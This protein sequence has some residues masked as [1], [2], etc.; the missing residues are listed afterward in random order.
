MANYDKF[1]KQ[2][3]SKML[4]HYDR[5]DE[6][7][8]E[9]I[10]RSRSHLN[11]NLAPRAD[12]AQMDI[13][14]KRISKVKVMNRADVNVLCCWVVTMPKTLPV[15]KEPEFFRN[16]Y[17]FLENR[18]G[19]DN[20]V[21]AYVHKD[22]VTPHMHFAFIPVVQDKKRDRLKVNANECVTRL[23]L[24]K[25]HG[26]LQEYLE[27]KLECQVD[28]LNEAT[29]EG[30]KSIA[31]LKRES[32]VQRLEK[33]T[34]KATEIVSTAQYRARVIED[35]AKPLEAECEAVQSMLDAFKTESNTNGIKANYSKL[36]F[37]EEIKSYT[38]EP[39]R[40]NE[41]LIIEKMLPKIDETHAKL[42]KDLAKIKE[43]MT[44]QEYQK[45]INQYHAMKRELEA[46]KAEN[47]QLQQQL[48]KYKS[49]YGELEEPQ[50]EK[51]KKIIY[52]SKSKS[53]SKDDGME[54][55]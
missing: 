47:T 2:W 10:D 43:S 55:G 24:Q 35:M 8:K 44:Y 37:G 20:V 34:T 23:D 4:S 50:Q 49:R 51:S 5:T 38:V 33:A 1:T 30:N 29:R 45:A 11:Y 19:K 12:E 39:N 54:I 32:A 14:K 26:E 53:N 13:F 22:E 28:I 7:P 46:S 21:S 36:G 40:M 27:A 17:E 42:E 18:Y 52:K 9:H 48:N 6:A 16:T 31:E 41:L 25:I 3:L 15:E